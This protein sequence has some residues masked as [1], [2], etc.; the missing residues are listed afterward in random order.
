MRRHLRAAIA[1]AMVALTAGCTATAESSPPEPRS[2]SAI[3]LPP[4]GGFD[5]QLGGAYDPPDGTVVVAR[6]S[7]DPPAKNRYGIC[8]LNAFQ[9][10]PGQAADW[11]GL[12]LEGADGPVADPGWPDEY[13]LDTSTAAN[14]TAIA[15]R[16]GA[17]IAGCAKAG[18]DAVEFDN[19]DSYLRSNH[20]LTPDDNL[21]L[22]RLLIAH[23]H[24]AGLAA[25]QKNAL[26]LAP[27]G[28]A[29]GF[30][31]A[32]TEECGAYRECAG[33]QAAYPIVLD[34]EYSTADEYAALC[35]SGALPER[36][37]RRDRE[38]VKAGADGY[39]FGRCD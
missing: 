11:K 30:D 2:P 5:Y 18:Y 8:Y 6:D 39:A 23:A 38:L 36:S 10:Q 15:A 20:A 13:L 27:E 29:A 19:L 4:A 37:V 3:A 26:E 22:A 32:V 34:I 25:G 35:R 24:A 7:T 21:A 31:F 33:Y 9:S 12:L 17:L 14:R 28:R 16:V 1:L